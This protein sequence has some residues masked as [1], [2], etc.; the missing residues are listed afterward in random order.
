M[1]WPASHIALISAFTA[2]EPIAEDRIQY[3]L[4]QHSALFVNS[5]KAKGAAPSKTKDFLLFYDPWNTTALDP[6]RYSE[7]DRASLSALDNL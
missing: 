1:D 2:V 3:T 5:N 4:A 7:S 6:T